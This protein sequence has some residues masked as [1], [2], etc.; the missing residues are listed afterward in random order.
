LLDW[1][2]NPLV[3][4]YFAVA[5]EPSGTV[6]RVYALQ[7]S[8]VAEADPNTDPFKIDDVKFYIP[9]ALVP[10]IVAQR[11]LFTAHPDP[12]AILRATGGTE[13]SH[14]F[15]IQ[16]HERG[17][18]ARRLYGLGIDASHIMADLDGL[19][20]SL[21]WQYRSGVALGRFGF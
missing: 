21:S 11:G 14:Y 10:R 19:C 20:A 8:Q 5:S 16:P 3:A 6:A 13:G 1:T 2:K 7:G 18:F 9:S 17:Y 15:D 12:T 4:A